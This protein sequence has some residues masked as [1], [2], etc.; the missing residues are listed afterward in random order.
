MSPHRDQADDA[1]EA[2][3]DGGAWKNEG[4][5]H[6]T[7]KRFQA[8]HGLLLRVIQRDGRAV[9]LGVL[10][11]E[12]RWEW[13]RQITSESFVDAASA[14]EHFGSRDDSGQ[15]GTLWNATRCSPSSSVRWNGMA[16]DLL[17]KIP[18]WLKSLW[19]MENELRNAARNGLI[20]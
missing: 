6:E 15:C 10:L 20:L 1:V 4:A 9:H 14:Q 8:C 2:E 11:G 16:N 17:D 12:R 5:V 19:H 18:E 13:G 3:A 7:G